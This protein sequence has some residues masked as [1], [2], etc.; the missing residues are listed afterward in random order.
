VKFR[1]LYWGGEMDELER[2]SRQVHEWQEDKKYAFRGVNL[3]SFTNKRNPGPVYFTRA[4][5]QA[6]RDELSGKPSEWFFDWSQWRGQDENGVW[7]EYA[8]DPRQEGPNRKH[9]VFKGQVLGD[10]R[11]TLEE[12][13]VDDMKQQFTVESN[14]DMTYHGDKPIYVG[15]GVIFNPGDTL[16]RVDVEEKSELCGANESLVNSESESPLWIEWEGGKCPVDGEIG[17]V[18]TLRNGKQITRKAADLKWEDLGCSSDI[19]AYRP[20]YPNFLV[21][22][23]KDDGITDHELDEPVEDKSEWVDG[24]CPVGEICEW[25]GMIEREG[26]TSDHWS[27]GNRIECLEHREGES[28]DVIA[29]FWNIDDKTA[30]SSLRTHDDKELYRPIKSDKDVQIEKM[31]NIINENLTAG[32][33]AEALYKANC[34]IQESDDE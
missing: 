32:G 15:L 30:D 1:Y 7:L 31:V 21:N 24:L 29:V 10:W 25:I 2:L 26:Y 23:M 11:D 14:G 19:I 6:K 28:G 9:V 4:K 12:R 34:R 13:V 3:F 8:C 18:A 27:R 16:V 5:W 22:P 17:V 20:N 33:I